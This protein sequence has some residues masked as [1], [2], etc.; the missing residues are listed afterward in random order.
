[1]SICWD[2]C[3][4]LNTFQE[5]IRVVVGWTVKETGGQTGSH[6]LPAGKPNH[7]PFFGVFLFF[8]VI[9]FIHPQ[10]KCKVF[11][12]IAN[13]RFSA[14][15]KKQTTNLF[16]SSGSPKVR[17]EPKPFHQICKMI[18]FWQHFEIG[19]YF[20]L[21]QWILTIYFLTYSLVVVVY[22]KLMV[23]PPGDIIIFR[24][25]QMSGRS[26]LFSLLPNRITFNIVFPNRITPY[27]NRTIPSLK[28]F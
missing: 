28:C 1:M 3:S 12:G 18:G 11:H 5:I 23:L 2:H 10:N 7:F 13:H 25:R 22:K 20:L 16:I 15:Q 24:R 19:S 8:A 6:R 21:L 27:P 14:T 17:S 26:R 4:A 9:F